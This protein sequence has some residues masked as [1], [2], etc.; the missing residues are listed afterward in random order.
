MTI[1]PGRAEWVGPRIR[2]LTADN[3]SPMTGKGTNSYLL[4]HGGALVLVDPGPA[5]DAH[6]A[7]LRAS[8]Q[9]E[10]RIGLIIVTHA[11]LDHSAG[12][13]LI[14][15]QTGAAVLAFGGC[16]SGRSEVMRRLEASGL[17]GGGEGI[18]RSFKPDRAVIDGE[19]L[20]GDW[21]AIEIIHTPGHMGGHICIGYDD[22]L[23]SGDHAMGWSTSLV[24]PPDGD[25][26]D[27]MRSLHRL[28]RRRWHRMLPG[29][30]PEVTDPAG[31]LAELI[32]H[33]EGREAAILRAL[34]A[35]PAT[36]ADL[37]RHIYTELP[38]QLLPAAE[39]TVL[40]HLIDLW[41]RN[42]I[43][44]ATDIAPDTAFRIA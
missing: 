1:R 22:T 23:L 16:N 42:E 11:H 12:T 5:L 18:D 37:A 38:R 3:P 32:R 8:L 26:G 25:M 43:R 21:G 10:E 35:G 40:A 7:G 6:A 14:A 27:Y 36:A 9:A 34:H 33:R 41:Q 39:R 13:S 29:H 31:R 28:A 19:R 15:R 17:S 44:T 4:G 2:R 24:S 30:G 20:E